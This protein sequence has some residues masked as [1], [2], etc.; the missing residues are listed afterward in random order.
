MVSMLILKRIFNFKPV[1]SVAVEWAPRRV[2][3]NK[4]LLFQTGELELLFA[5]A[6]FCSLKF[7]SAPGIFTLPAP[8]S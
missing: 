1:V 7:K 5:Q 3:I 2:G 4:L 6:G 8:C